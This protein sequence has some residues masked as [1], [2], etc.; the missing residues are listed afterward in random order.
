MKCFI[1][2]VDAALVTFYELSLGYNPKLRSSVLK[3]PRAL[4]APL[5]PPAPAAGAAAPPVPGGK[6]PKLGV[7]AGLNR[8]KNEL[9]NGLSVG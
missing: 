6:P 4:K 8:F 9:E 1:G 7:A 2:K 3:P 5:P